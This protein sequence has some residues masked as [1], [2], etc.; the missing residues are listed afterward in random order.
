MIFVK[1]LKEGEMLPAWYGVAFYDYACG[2]CVAVPIPFNVIYAYLRLIYI[3]IRV[4]MKAVSNN[5]RE[6]YWQGYTEGKKDSKP[7]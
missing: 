5:P 4:G 6:A 3:Y 2:R 1:R 7:L